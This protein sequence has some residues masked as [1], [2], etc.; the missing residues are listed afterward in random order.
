MES[1]Q[2]VNQW[3]ASISNE[4]WQ[5]DDGECHLN[6]AQGEHFATLQL[7]SHRLLLMLS[8]QSAKLSHD[9]ELHS[10]LLLL[11][12]HPDVIGFASFSLSADDSTIV[13]ASS[14]HRAAINLVT[15][16]EFWQRSLDVREALFSALTD[17]EGA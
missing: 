17:V 16:A 5:L 6:D 9:E 10:N 15:L 13:L 7:N 11:N 14:L 1:E 2:V 4:Q 8:L 3:L 12:N